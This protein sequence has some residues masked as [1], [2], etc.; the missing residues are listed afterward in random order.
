MYKILL[1]FLVNTVCIIQVVYSYEYMEE[2][3]GFIGWL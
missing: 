3:I 1:D 2:R